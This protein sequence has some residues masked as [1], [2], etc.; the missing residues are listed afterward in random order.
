MFD[1]GNNCKRDGHGLYLIIVCDEAGIF[2]AFDFVKDGQA[3]CSLTVKK[4][5]HYG[6]I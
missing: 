5:E 1:A 2:G 4:N 3:T 6:I